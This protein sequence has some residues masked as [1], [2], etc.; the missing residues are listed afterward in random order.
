MTQTIEERRLKA[1]AA[2]RAWRAAHPE[3]SRASVKAYRVKHPERFKAQRQAYQKKYAAILRE[4]KRL[5][6]IK[7]KDRILARTKA[8]RKANAAMIYAKV[9]AWV[10]AN[11]DKK[12]A[13][14]AKRRA[15]KR[16]APINDFTGEQWQE[17]KA[18][19]GNKCVYCGKK[20]ARLEQDHIIPLI[21][22]GPHT[23]SNIVPAC[24]SCNSKKWTGNV[25]VP[26]QPLLL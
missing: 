18:H 23:R 6:A 7:N 10:K 4:R 26:V 21:A 20:F 8:Y 5:Y 25:L 2:R 16:N 19:Y 1:V 24:R 14:G 12:Q 11:P 9:Q 15:L 17:M 22:G 3:E 13:Q